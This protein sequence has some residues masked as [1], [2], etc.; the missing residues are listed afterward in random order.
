MTGVLIVCGA[1]IGEPR[2]ASP[3]LAEVLATADVVAA[4]DTRRVRRLAHALGVTIG[5]RV[6]SCYDAVE[7][8]RAATLT[9]YLLAGQTVAL[10]TDAGMPAVSDPG[11]RVVAAAAAAGVPVTVVPGPSAV[12][13]ALAVSG[14]PSDRFT[15]EGFLPRRGGERRGRLRE[16]AAERRTMV[17]LEAPHRLA[18]SLTDLAAV[19]GTE[20]AAV[21]C[22]ELTKT[23]EEVVRGDLGR[24]V[25]WA[26]DGRE[27]RGEFTLVV[28]GAAVGPRRLGFADLATSADRADASAARAPVAAGRAATGGSEPAVDGSPDGSGAAG[29]AEAADPL[30]EGADETSAVGQE[31]IL[32]DLRPPGPPTAAELAAAVAH[33]EAAGLS[34]AEARRAVMDRFGVSR[35]AVYE[36]L[37]VNRAGDEASRRSP[38]R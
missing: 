38:G 28:A 11:F 31:P 13:A 34:R 6:T 16:L 25:A 12:T 1:P 23:W 19:F 7:G 2:D 15:F 22:R 18:S 36:A 9:E 5:G 32:G 8:A 27:I 10:I 30:P 26:T 20:R 21:A 37:V 3:R 35:A 29:P 14:L 4:E 17:F 33:H 24:L